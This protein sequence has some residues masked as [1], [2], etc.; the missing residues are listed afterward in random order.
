MNDRPIDERTGWQIPEAYEHYIGFCRHDGCRNAWVQWGYCGKHLL[1][2]E[3][4]SYTDKDNT[5]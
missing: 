3:S 1:A 5:K 2:V 4:V